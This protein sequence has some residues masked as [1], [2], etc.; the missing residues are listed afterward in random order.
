VQCPRAIPVVAAQL[1]HDGR[2]G[3]RGELD[4]TARIEAIERLE[5][6]DPGDLEK[7][8]EWLAPLGVASGQGSHEPAVALDELL[9]CSVVAVA[10]PA[11]DQTSLSGRVHACGGVGFAGI[12][13]GGS[14]SNR[15]GT[16][17]PRA[18]PRDP[19][20]RAARITM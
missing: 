12:G 13:K 19:E 11:L 1:T 10:L 18:C 6:A 8:V 5:E 14:L 16:G 2:R 15:P 7:V 3:I 20:P 4:L 9:A 17:A